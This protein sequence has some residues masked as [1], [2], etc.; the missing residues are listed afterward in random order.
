MGAM[1]AANSALARVSASHV[2]PGARTY[3]AVYRP[4]SDNTPDEPPGPAEVEDPGHD[5]HR[6]AWSS[7]IPMIRS[8]AP[9]MRNANNTVIAIAAI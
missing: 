2:R 7:W 8:Q 1:K 5:Y 3:N 4:S 6:L 9:E